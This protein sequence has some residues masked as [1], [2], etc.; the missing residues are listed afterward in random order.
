MIKVSYKK[1]AGYVIMVN[2]LLFAAVTTALLAAVVVPLVTTSQTATGYQRSVQALMAGNSTIEEVVYRLKK[3]YDLPATEEL[4]IGTATSSISVASEA[5]AKTIQVATEDFDY[6]RD[7]LVEAST[8][9]GVTFNYGLQAGRGG[10]L[11]SGGAIINGNVYS[12]GNIIGS[13]GPRITGSAFVANQSNPTAAV[14]HGSVFPPAHSVAFGGNTTPQDFAQSF[15]VATSA[16]VT[17][18]RLYMRRTTAGW[19]NDIS[20]YITEDNGGK[21]KKTKLDTT[22]ISKTQ[23]TTSYNYISVPLS[24]ALTLTPGQTYWIV[25]DTSTTWGAYYE[26]GAALSGYADGVGKTG[27]WSNGNGGSWGNTSPSGLDI[28]LDLY[29]GGETG[30]IKGVTIGESGGDAWAHEVTNSTIYGSLYCQV[31]GGNNKACDTSRPDPSEQAYPVSDGNI[32]DWKAEAST[33]G[34]IIG[35][36]SYGGADVDTLGPVII[37]GNLSVGSG[38]V[39]NIAGTMYVMGNISVSGG[40]IIQLDS[41][42]ADTPG[43]LVSD[44]LISMTGGGVFQGTGLEGSYMLVLTTSD[45]HSTTCG[46]DTAITV[47]GGTDSVI[48]NAQQGAVKFTGGA[49]ANQVTAY[50]VIMS[51]GTQV[52]YLE[53]LA[54]V[55]FSSGPG[56]SWSIDRWEEI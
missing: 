16:P 4:I 41:S 21:P 23:I 18:V 9:A 42:Y 56:G 51:G 45:C 37:T 34:V 13:G 25:F 2:V 17:S 15:T 29:V 47:S 43:I 3:G 33:G 53:G 11:M 48:L 12:N 55:N 14:S 32:A 27:T 31:S 5:D 52:N 28:Y 22:T 40:G 26:L 1:H 6:A 19:M 49:T 24:S 50:E 30:S 36:V 46:S 35:D 20:M 39:L 8:A 44:S 54:D 38:A 10:F 7:F